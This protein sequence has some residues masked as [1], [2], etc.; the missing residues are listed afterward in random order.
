MRGQSDGLPTPPEARPFRA[1][2]QELAAVVPPFTVAHLYRTG[3]GARAILANLAV[4]GGLTAAA[5]G[6]TRGLGNPAQWASLAL[7]LYAAFSWFQSLGR[8]DPPAAALIF[9]TPSLVLAALGCA[10]LSFSGYGFGFWLA[11]FFVRVH[12]VTSRAS[13]SW[14]VERP[15]AAA[16]W[17]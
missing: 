5:A 15:P 4:A 9:R 14:S 11:P 3:A 16:G 2:F 6:M 7:G 10:A 8:R 12:D 13:G 17:G 1:F